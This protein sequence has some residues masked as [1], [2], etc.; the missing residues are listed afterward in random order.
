MPTN[1]PPSSSQVADIVRNYYKNRNSG[2]SFGVPNQTPQ[3]QL[4]SMPNASKLT[5]TEKWLYDRLPGWTAKLD[6]TGISKRL[7]DF[8][9]SWLGKGLEFM[10]VLAE[11]FERSVGVGEQILQAG[12]R[13]FDYSSPNL[14]AAWYA[15][16]LY[17]DTANLPQEV[18]KDGKVTIRI[19]TDLPGVDGMV[20]ARAQIKRYLDLGLD[21]EQA[22][23][24]VK[25]DYYN[26]LGALALRAQM[27]DM[28]G[29]MLG[30]PLNLVTAYIKP[31][32]ALKVARLRGLSKVAGGADELLGRAD[33]VGK[34]IA[35]AE[36]ADDIVKLG[37]EAYQLASMAGDTKRAAQYATE[38]ATA[39]RKAGKVEEA[40]RFE[41][42]AVR[43]AGMTADEA[44]A[45]SEEALAALGKR[46]IT[47]FEKFA[48]AATGGD[49]LRP[50]RVAKFLEKTP[51]LKGFIL[52]PESKAKELMTVLGDNIG[53]NVVSRIFN[54]PNAEAEFASYIRRVSKGATG[55][56][57]GHALLT[58]EGRTVQS[59]LKGA[60]TG[61]E[62]MFQT[63][64][65][66]GKE[67]AI[68]TAVADLLGETPTKLL[69][70]MDE[71]PGVLMDMLAKKPGLNPAIDAMIQAGELTPDALRAL[72][73]T[74]ANMPYNKEM[75]FAKALDAIET[76]AMRQAVVQFGVKERGVVTRWADAMKAAESLAFLR[77][78][79]AYPFRN[80]WNNDVTML[81]RGLFG[82]YNEA[83]I[84]KFWDDFGVMPKRLA[85][86]ISP[87][88]IE[89]VT[90]EADRIL[91][92]ALR[93]GNYGAPERVKDFFQNVKLGKAD[94][95]GY[96]GQRIEKRASKLAF[97]LGTQQ[98]LRKYFRPKGLSTYVSRSVMDEIED[99]D[100]DFARH[101]DNA[102]RASG[103]MEKKF[104]E[105]LGADLHLNVD[106]ILDDVTQT[107]GAEVRDLLGDELL[108]YIDQN[109]PAAMKNGTLDD[110][111][112]QTRQMMNDHI[113]D[114]FEKQLE[115]VVEHVK[116]QAVAGG[117]NV[118]AKK[119]SEAQDI[120][121]GAHV[122]YSQR[123]PEATRLAREASR[124]GDY[125]T[126]RALWKQEQADARLFYD[127]AFKRVDAYIQGLEE[128]AKD[129]GGKGV[130]MP[131]A[132]VRRTF[133]DWRAG[134]RQFFDEKNRLTDEF[135]D[136]FDATPKGQRPP[137]SID[138]LNKQIQRMYDG[139][140]EQE[141]MLNQK[142]D[143]LLASSIE[144][145][146][147]KKAFLNARDTLAD[148]K[149]AD[150]KAVNDMY[151]RTAD[152]A[153]E[154]RQAA[155]N[156]FWAERVGRYQ[157]MRNVEQ[158][159]IAI[160]HGDP[161]AA[162]MF[163]EAKKA[164]DTNT[165]EAFDIY[166]LAE[167]HGVESTTKR[168]TRNDRRILNTINKYLGQKKEDLLKGAD[169]A[170]AVKV[171][172]DQLPPAV[173]EKMETTARGLL[174]ELRAG[175]AG[176]RVSDDGGRTWTRIGSTNA[177]W[178]KELYQR[179]V[180][181]KAVDKAL[182]K[183]IENHGKDKGVN[184]ERLK[185]VIIDRFRYGDKDTGTPPDLYALS[186]LGASDKVMKEALDDYNDMTRQSLTLEDAIAQASPSSLHDPTQPYY[187]DAGNLVL[188]SRYNKL[189]DVPE[190]AAR[191][192][193]A[194]RDAEKGM[195]APEPE[196]TPEFIADVEKVIPNPM[197]LDLGLDMM[198]YGRSQTALDAV[199][200]SAKAAATKTP[201]RLTDL[202]EHVQKQV[203]KAVR[204]AKNDMASTRHQAI[205]FGEWRRDSALLNYNRRTNFDTWLGNVAPF[206]FW[207]THS[208]I[209]WAI[210][211]IDRPAMITNYMRMRE[212]FATAGL[213]REGMPTRAKGKIRIPIPFAPDWMGEGFIDPLRVALPFDNWLSPF[214]KLQQQNES[215]D[216]RTTRL[217]EQ[218]LA[219]GTITQEEF[220]EA[221]ETRSG[222]TWEYARTKAA[223]NDNA[224]NFDSFDFATSLANP[225]APLMWA[226]NAA[227]GNK[228][229]IGSFTPM[230]RM[231]RNAATLLG[232][233]DW[234][235][236]KWNLEA[237]VRRQLG[238]PAFDKWD[239]Y[240][241]D[242]SL[243]NLAGDGSFTI[244][245]VKEAMA[246]SAM[247]QQ[248]KLTPEQAKEMSEAYREGVKRSN[249]EYTGGAGNFLLQ[250]LGFGI[251]Y[252]PK[253]E[254]EL[255]ALA[256][257]FG[258]AYESYKKA[259]D[260]LQA[261]IEA[262]PEMEEELA[263]EAW[264]QANPRLANAVDD[265]TQF[266]DEN[267]EYEARLGI[268]DEP[269]ER[270]HKFMIDRTWHAF[271]QLPK[272]NQNE[273]R[274][275]LGND[276]TD[277]FLTR[278]TRDYD[279]IPTEVLGIWQKLMGVDPLGG[280]TADQ[281]VLKTLYG[282]IQLT[283]PE[284]AWRVQAF[285]DGR[286]N[287]FDGWYEKQTAYYEL[288]KGN[289]RKEYLRN[290]PDL[291]QYWDFRKE[292]MR[293]NPDLVPYLTD[294][295][296]AIERA[297]N[298]AR[299]EAAV[300]T[301]QEMAQIAAKLPPYV[302]DVVFDY[303]QS[304]EPLPPV[305]IEELEYLSGSMGLDPQLMVNILGAR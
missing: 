143:D 4:N 72:S 25:D 134:W 41:Q 190:E 73:K 235:N 194:A 215:I 112:L 87:A 27:N 231:M 80:K 101:F 40:A 202:P 93:G 186:E 181:K 117:P 11:G 167:Q 153:P 223:G 122:E 79:P 29:H 88:Q 164:A 295:P 21:P 210:E 254:T 233:E 179:G 118:W 81:A 250:Q 124:T 212:F 98:F 219:E 28:W 296:K 216:G 57:Y 252:I 113:Q 137:Q 230:S 53:A 30:D 33:E 276:F 84:T 52:T 228:E 246:I 106:S 187:D 91:D 49:P 59:F 269:E 259:N 201:T 22:I 3:Q 284:T 267:P 253:G 281:R 85:D 2:G 144:D 218:Q 17:W 148:M 301:A 43:L 175:E 7:D 289:Q 162:A 265:L 263:Q 154:E 236:S 166:K 44:A 120:F 51:V 54:S 188:P 232:V 191:K 114:L 133:E 31:V 111:R 19:P 62:H 266:F 173:N 264:A 132:D 76:Q 100:P 126:A 139:M 65:K 119:M 204:M 104:D 155:W 174:E 286:D 135:W 260:S 220:D 63:Y 214:D 183:I 248:G 302:R 165:G 26:G 55:I 102:I 293:N 107:T 271:N 152:M 78:N 5:Q 86:D 213:E 103:A 287:N 196:V 140:V 48:I 67:R 200:D 94:F 141:D 244:D 6:E 172:R 109:L 226:Y 268:F 240:R 280:L 136:A 178:Y 58:L 239:D 171:T 45:F 297:K 242:R 75:F 303:A 163:T 161:Q 192:A 121:W 300:P 222:M 24:R 211:S 251:T 97:T 221:V 243:A 60:E 37:D 258:R 96:W 71:D 203:M 241:I 130:Q 168:G 128:A 169:E 234:N 224:D 129:L 20:E 138:D 10:D 68:L 257:D 66:V 115:N 89:K 9:K 288:P 47:R 36:N 279:S 147:A 23:A 127:R 125:K 245:E 99:L 272:L 195:P 290:N 1:N 92:E 270:L 90:T 282:K 69:K 105:L 184:V 13:N 206:V 42:E 249:Q 156:K 131:W 77:L 256:D 227:F 298:A 283:D 157:Q 225:H 64:Q 142:I 35:T 247:V 32:E 82:V 123:M 176:K 158:A 305:V 193:F 15:G 255:R 159:S 278:E 70:L 177:D 205:K 304:G 74:L 146:A 294:D 116:A 83:T 56:E 262:H 8:S 209:N 299:T 150:K 273:L 18:V 12:V 217:L 149:K 275:Q 208:A 50:G 199:I 237:K 39:A 238:L 108:A 207:T 14:R 34:L 277:A 38:A 185:Q 198:N 151:K 189:E 16:H 197:P 145:P 292:F 274:D 95:A 170:K 61:I 285:Y 229:D 261:Y 160:Q 46:K 110:F 180:S 291:K 182:E